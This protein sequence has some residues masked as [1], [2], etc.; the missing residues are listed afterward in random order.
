M[1]SIKHLTAPTRLNFLNKIG[2]EVLPS[3]NEESS[4]Y[5]FVAI[6]YYLQ[7]HV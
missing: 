7:E 2:K 1:Q 5:Q 3:R 6:L 4:E